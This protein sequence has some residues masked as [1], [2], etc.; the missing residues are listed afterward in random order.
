[1]DKEDE[2]RE[3]QASQLVYNG[4]EVLEVYIVDY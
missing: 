3:A 2:Q 4:L 1:M